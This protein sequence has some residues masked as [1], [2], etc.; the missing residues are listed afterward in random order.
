LAFFSLKFLLLFLN[1]KSFE[2]V[3][4][5]FLFHL[6]NLVLILPLYDGHHLLFLDKFEDLDVVVVLD[7][8]LLVKFGG[9]GV[10][11]LLHLDLLQLENLKIFILPSV[12]PFRC[13]SS[14]SPGA[15]ST[16]HFEILFFP[17][18][19]PPA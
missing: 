17:A 7:P 3:L 11:L 1:G 4:L 10:L 14:L 15:E 16:T 9:F 19:A 12:S 18:A 6:L 5:Y 13:S 8:Q 2:I